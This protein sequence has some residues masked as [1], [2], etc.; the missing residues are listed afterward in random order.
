MVNEHVLLGQADPQSSFHLY[1]SLQQGK[2]T[3]HSHWHRSWLG[4]GGSLW[5]A[6]LSSWSPT[7]S[8]LLLDLSVSLPVCGHLHETVWVLDSEP[9]SLA[10]QAHFLDRHALRPPRALS[11]ILI[12]EGLCPHL[13]DFI[14]LAGYVG[15]CFCCKPLSILGNYWIIY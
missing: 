6:H 13:W 14:E 12:C 4:A 2:Q 1:K 10:F 3:P 8:Y 9:C 7:P 5:V 11:P 15:H